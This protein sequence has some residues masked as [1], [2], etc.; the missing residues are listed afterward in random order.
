MLALAAVPAPMLVAPTF[1]A[2]QERAADH[3]TGLV[4]DDGIDRDPDQSD[5]KAADVQGY[6]EPVYD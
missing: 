2:A 5:P 6:G 4:R 3:R 1:A